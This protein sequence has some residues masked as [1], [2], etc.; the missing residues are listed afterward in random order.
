MLMRAPFFLAKAKGPDSGVMHVGEFVR[1][2]VSISDALLGGPSKAS[3]FFGSSPK[4]TLLLSCGFV[5]GFSFLLSW[6]ML[7]LV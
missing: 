4:S 5:S 1:E 2:G 7:G 3:F 6:I